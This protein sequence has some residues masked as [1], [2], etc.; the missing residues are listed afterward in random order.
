[1]LNYGQ[2]MPYSITAAAEY[3]K[4]SRRDDIDAVAASSGMTREEIREI[5][6]HIFFEKHKLHE[7]YGLLHPDYDMAVAWKRLSEGRPEERDVLLLKH[8][9]L[10]SRLE[11][12]YNL[13]IAEAHKR[14]K[15]TYNWEKAL[16]EA[17]GID[18]EKDGL[19]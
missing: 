4:I 10:E 7:G 16:E 6:R 12:E 5:R 19:L 11:K 18:G 17:V 9:L 3:K 1:M 2:K 14:A 13:S 15:A 8:E